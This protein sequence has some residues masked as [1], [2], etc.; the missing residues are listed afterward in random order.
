MIKRKESVIATIVTVVILTLMGAG[1]YFFSGK[2]VAEKLLSEQK[3]KTERMLSEKLTLS[4]E[5]EQLKKDIQAKTNVNSK[6]DKEMIAM[7]KQLSQKES[8]LKQLD[9]SITEAQR[10]KKQLAE[11]AK[12]KELTDQE[13]AVLQEQLKALQQQNND[14]LYDLAVL[15]EDNNELAEKNALLS[16]M[17]ANNYELEALTKKD[18]LTIKSKRTKEIIAGFDVPIGMSEQLKFTITSPDGKKVASNSSKT[19]TYAVNENVEANTVIVASTLNTVSPTDFTKRVTLSYKPDHKI[20]RGIY[21][22]EI[23]AED[24]YVGSAQIRL[25]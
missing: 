6:M 23:Y 10:Y 11:L 7:Q 14:M 3:L 22:I 1:L 19:I 8:Q 4:K 12:N 9:Q 2:N 25:K 5:I 20:E 16:Q 17:M 15:K 21:H 18:K 24:Q 13:L